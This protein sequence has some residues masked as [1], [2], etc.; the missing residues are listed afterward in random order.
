ARQQQHAAA[1]AWVEAALSVGSALGGLRYGA[2]SWRAPARRQLGGLLAG[3]GLAV[4]VAGAASNLYVLA[5]VVAGVGLFVAPAI[6]VTYLVADEAAAPEHR[7][8]AAALVNSAYNCGSALGTAGIGLLLGG[9]PA[10]A[11]SGLPLPAGFVL[12]ALPAL[13]VGAAALRRPKPA[14]TGDAQ[15]AATVLIPAGA[16]QP[17]DTR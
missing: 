12:A 9:A 2:R 14:A 16:A 10:G 1:V 8:R 13:L 5:A 4:A 17:A 7:T 11:A 15:P 6:T 3:L